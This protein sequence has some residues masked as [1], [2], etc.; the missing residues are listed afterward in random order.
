MTDTTLPEDIQPLT[1]LGYFQESLRTWSAFSHTTA[2]LMVGQMQNGYAPFSIASGDTTDREPVSAEWLRAISDLNLR[3]WQ[4]T[5]RLLESFPGWMR[6]P[7]YSNGTALVDWFDQIQ[8]RGEAGLPKTFSA[9]F[10]SR[11][12]VRPA[13]IARPEGEVDD[14]TR[15][16]GIGKKLSGLLNELGIFCFAQI[17]DWSEDEAAWIDD[18]L[19][20]KGRV[21]RED[22][23]GQARAFSSQC[24]QVKA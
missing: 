15:I 20:F 13:L 7:Q 4:N 18:Y 8:R 24:G 17:A 19:A 16:K 23:I 6:T 9:A 2:R 3:H 12:P 22:W 14:L 1:P 10:P 21:A 11:H 5:A